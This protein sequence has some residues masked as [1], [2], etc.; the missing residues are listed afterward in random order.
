MNRLE[1]LAS[2]RFCRICFT[3][4]EGEIFSEILNT[5]SQMELLSVGNI[6]VNHKIID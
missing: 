2:N 6:E 5:I 1:E 3:Q 4:D